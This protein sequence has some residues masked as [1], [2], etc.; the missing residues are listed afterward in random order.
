MVHWQPDP[1]ATIRK[2]V[3]LLIGIRW[4]LCWTN[5]KES[6]VGKPL[7]NFRFQLSWETCWKHLASIKIKDVNWLKVRVE[8]Q[9]TRWFASDFPLWKNLNCRGKQSFFYQTWV[10][11]LLYKV[12]WAC[13]KGQKHVVQIDESVD[14]TGGDHFLHSSARL[15]A[16]PWD[17]R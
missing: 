12:S 7:A 4:E 5:K 1:L 13:L 2:K 10:S 11:Q 15:S 16:S 17:Y 3:D 14:V 6:S 9:K 8:H